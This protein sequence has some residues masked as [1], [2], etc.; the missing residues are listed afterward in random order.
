MK[1]ENSKKEYTGLE[2]ETVAFDAEDVITASG[3]GCEKD[4]PK[5]VCTMLIYNC[6]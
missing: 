1:K 4:C 2:L 6:K 5:D 3:A